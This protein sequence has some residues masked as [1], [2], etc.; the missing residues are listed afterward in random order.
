MGSPVSPIVANRFMEWLEESAIRTFPYKLSLWKRYVDDTIVA[1]C[2]ELIEDFTTHLNA[3]HPA[4]K[5]TREEESEDGT[6]PML[7]AITK[8]EPSG[9]M[10]FTVYRKATHTDQY[11]Q[12]DSNQPRQHKLGVIRTLYHRAQCLISNPED[13][14]KE[15]EHIKKVLSISGY[16]RSAWVNA[17]KPSRPRPRERVE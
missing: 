9:R 17:T 7:D 13:K 1:I 11:L 2:D 8:R 5:F 14:A 15:L 4:I 3:Q 12:F 6:L 10:S 16:T